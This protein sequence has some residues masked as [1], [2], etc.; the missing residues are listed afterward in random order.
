MTNPR[1]ARQLLRSLTWKD[2]FWVTSGVPVSV[3]FTVGGIAPII[4]KPAWAVW[5]ISITI[6]FVQSF[7]YAEISGLYP[8]K[9]GGASVYGALAWVRYSK[10]VAPISV[11]CNWLAWSPILALG[12]SLAAGYMLTTLFP[13][14]AH[15]HTWQ[16]TLLDL[17]F[18][19]DGLALRINATFLLGMA[20]LLVT[21]WLQHAG[22][23]AA[24]RTQRILGIASL[25]P[26]L[27]VSLVP[28][29]TG[30]MPSSHFLP[31]LPL[32]HDR[33]G[34][35]VTG[36]WNGHGTS[37]AMGAM[38][39]AC[40]ST[41][42]FET[43]VC[44]T[45]EFR[46]PQRDTFRAIFASGLL[47][48]FMFTVVPVAFQGVLG[49]EG[50]LAPGIV[51]G[52]GVGS[53]MAGFVGGGAVVAHM[54]VVM[55][56]LAV[57]LLVM[58]SMMGSSRT[59]YQ[60]SVDGWLPR[61]LAHLNP[62]GAPT[63]AMWTDLVFNLFLLLMSNYM[64]VLA[65]SNVCYMIFVFL[66]LQAGWIHRLDRPDWERPYRCGSWLLGIGAL[67]G[68]LDLAFAGAG[69]NFQGTHTL[70]NG[71]IAMTLILPVFLFRHYVQDRGHFPE[72]MK[73]DMDLPQAR[74]GMLPYLALA[75]AVAVVWISARLAV[76]S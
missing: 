32:E 1:S 28:L 29:F 18:I 43:A 62:H 25:A 17:G 54:I 45:R 30:D 51:D 6:G 21:F 75:A 33:S 53:V 63:R 64:A 49:L 39:L 57:L 76:L 72:S 10:F 20:F 9:S 55:L 73:R 41:F 46:D 13:P 19:A 8:H 47:C 5:I 36:N 2:A 38:F 40:W 3:L 67:C 15:I 35:V 60:A 22:A 68:Y 42:A 26:L 34:A 74:A 37:M 69:A 48:L 44:Y 4:G 58:T 31:L 16:I 50:M 23:S 65:I 71:L 14:E 59:L 52:S 11:W 70:R 61:Y 56:V 24:A 12:T 27:L 66:N 7:T